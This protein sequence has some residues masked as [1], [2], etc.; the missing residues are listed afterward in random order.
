[1]TGFVT[2]QRD[3][4][5][6][7]IRVVSMSYWVMYVECIFLLD[8]EIRYDLKDINRW[9]VWKMPND[10]IPSFN[11]FREETIHVLAGLASYFVKYI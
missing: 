2:P 5:H 9:N 8:E 6:S 3:Q 7:Q 1:M 4:A 11:S 10:I